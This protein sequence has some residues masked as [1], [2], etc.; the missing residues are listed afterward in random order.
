MTLTGPIAQPWVPL[1]HIVDWML[2]RIFCLSTGSFTVTGGRRRAGMRKRLSELSKS[3]GIT[4]AA[5]ACGKSARCFWRWMKS[6]SFKGSKAP[7]PNKRCDPAT[8]KA[9]RQ[10]FDYHRHGPLNLLAA[11]TVYNGHMGAGGLD[12]NAGEHFVLGCDAYCRPTVG[13]AAFI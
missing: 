2:S 11:L 8:P 7:L 1:T 10:E 4:S 3:F 9:E 5:S 13:R 12:K 6:R